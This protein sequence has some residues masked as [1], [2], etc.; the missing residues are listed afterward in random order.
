MVPS[1]K[2]HQGEVPHH[3]LRF[4]AD[5]LQVSWGLAAMTDPTQETGRRRATDSRQIP[6]PSGRIV[7]PPGSVLPPACPRL[8]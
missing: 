4:K 6:T 1:A 3:H 5:R 7:L 8:V 2:Q